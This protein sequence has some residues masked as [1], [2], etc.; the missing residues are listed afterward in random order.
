MCLTACGF[1]F[2]SS[3]VLFFL[4]NVHARTVSVVIKGWE[5]KKN[6]ST[7]SKYIRPTENTTLFVGRNVCPT[8]APPRVLLIVSSPMQN[9]EFR[10]AIRKTW[11]SNSTRL[12]NINVAFIVGFSEDEAI[13]VRK[14]CCR[15][16]V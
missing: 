1:H 2:S 4:P 15:Q 9:L 10:T 5:P 8:F 3:R 7:V 11:A 13:M 6:L 12:Y 16:Y 14:I